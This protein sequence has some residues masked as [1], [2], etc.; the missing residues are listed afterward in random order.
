[1]PVTNDRSSDIPQRSGSFQAMVR[2]GDSI[3]AYLRTG[4]GNPVILLRRNGHADALWGLVLA[5]V[6]K[7]YR[8]IIPERA[9]HG[10]EFADWFRSFVDGLGLG[11]AGVV[12][13]AHFG[14]CFSDVRLLDPDWLTTLVVVCDRDEADAVRAALDN[15]AMDDAT[16]SA[17]RREHAPPVSVITA[18]W[19]KSQTD[20][21]QQLMQLLAQSI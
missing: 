12:A 19:D 18:G 4:K 15:V 9:P 5:E 8:A 17:S 21:I 11:A 2:A 3:T 7:G 20:T 13:D 6:G 10:A 16:R 1:M 14:A